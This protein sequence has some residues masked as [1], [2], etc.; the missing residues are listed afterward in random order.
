M[1]ERNGYAHGIPSW[2]DLSSRDTAA[3]KAFYRALFGWDAMDVP[4]GD[5]PGS[6]AMFTRNGKVV[7]GMGELSADDTTSP[8]IWSTYLAVDDLDSTLDDVAAAGGTVI[9]PAMDVMDTGRMA[10]ITDPTGA[11]VGLW[12]AGTHR[13]AQLVNEHGTLTWNELLTDDTA[14]AEPF[15][16]GV[17]GYRAETT[18]MP[19]GQQYITFWADGNLEGH[20]AAGMMA[21]TPEMG[22][23][24]NYWGVYFAVDD[25]DAA[26]AKA[27]EHGGTILA[28]AFEV[29]TVGRFAV[30]M[31]PGGA[32]FTVATYENAVD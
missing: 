5:Q 25:V 7:A 32:T 26:V 6:Y 10:F 9:V 17:F 3:S 20:A 8:T 21:R 12:Q 24:P 4:T 2:V 13:G 29:P 15:Y 1:G 14:V 19:G 23:F 18:D 31:D 11:A 27:A 28:P 16:T 22:E 30:I